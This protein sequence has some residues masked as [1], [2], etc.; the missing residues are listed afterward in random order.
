MIKL[1]SLMLALATVLAEVRK[2]Y[3]VIPSRFLKMKGLT[4]IVFVF[5]DRIPLCVQC[6]DPNSINARLQCFNDLLKATD[7][8]KD[9]GD[10]PISIT[11]MFN[12][13]RGNL[14]DTY[15]L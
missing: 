13:N 5:E 6:T 11:L 12:G 7:R 14:Q 3:P 10:Q 2:V 8:L 15:Y 4:A 1:Q 9:N